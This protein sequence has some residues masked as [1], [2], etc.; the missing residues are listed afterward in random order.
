[1]VRGMQRAEAFPADDVGLRRVISQYYREGRG[2]S[3]EEA[4]KIAE[5]WG[6]WKGLASFYLIIATAMDI[7]TPQ[8]QR[9]NR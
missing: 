7:H 9:V 5:K 8:K 1:M 3:S 6:D 4:R 2:I